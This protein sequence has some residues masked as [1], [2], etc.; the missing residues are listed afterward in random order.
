M[1]EQTRGDHKVS[2]K[3]AELERQLEKLAGY[4]ERI[5]LGDY[6]QLINR[7]RRLVWINFISGLARGVG[8]GIGFTV[9]AALFVYT[10]QALE[11]LNLP[12]VGTFIADLVRIVQAQLHTPTT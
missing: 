2:A 3:G 4:M 10:L 5:N 9:L 7:P 6:I 12:I 8:I 1:N 11:V